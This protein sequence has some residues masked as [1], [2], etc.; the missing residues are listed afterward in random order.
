MVEHVSQG[1]DIRWL[2]PPICDEGQA[3]SAA[4]VLARYLGAIVR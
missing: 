3:Q 4:F 1:G 2:S